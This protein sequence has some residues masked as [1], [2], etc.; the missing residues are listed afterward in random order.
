MA[1]RALYRGLVKVVDPLVP[2]KLRPMWEHEAGP[3]TVFFWAPT[4]KWSLVVAGIADLA[5][6][7]DTLSLTQSTALTATG[8]FRPSPSPSQ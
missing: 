5:R 7:V 4:I 3:K 6:P 8:H 2:A 1:H